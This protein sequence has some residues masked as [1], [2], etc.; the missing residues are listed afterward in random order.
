MRFQTLHLKESKLFLIQEDITNS[1]K[2]FKK[3]NKRPE[4]K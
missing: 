1:I 3:E 2:V 4:E